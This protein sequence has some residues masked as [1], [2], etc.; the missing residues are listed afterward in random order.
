MGEK[1]QK[2]KSGGTKAVS[3]PI[4]W[5]LIKKMKA[6]AFW[7]IFHNQSFKIVLFFLFFFLQPECS[8]T[9]HFS[10][11]TPSFL[12]PITTWRAIEAELGPRHIAERS[13]QALHA[14]PAAVAVRPRPT[15]R[16]HVSPTSHPPGIPVQIA[17]LSKQIT[18]FYLK[19]RQRENSYFSH[20]FFYFCFSHVVFILLWFIPHKN[21]NGE[22]V[23][24]NKFN[25]REIECGSITN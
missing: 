23:K 16:R 24:V 14:L 25:F 4:A 20:C 21:E 1:C 9:Q 12:P 5:N 8:S 19:K 3:T 13:R 22:C 17:A 2:E 7:L 10:L 11:R 18:F 15:R 6:A